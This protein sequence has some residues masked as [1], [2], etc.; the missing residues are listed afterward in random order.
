MV[1]STRWRQRRKEF[2]VKNDPKDNSN[3][4]N[5][6]YVGIINFLSSFPLFYS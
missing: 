6:D 2:H 1:M 4:S 3:K 5:R